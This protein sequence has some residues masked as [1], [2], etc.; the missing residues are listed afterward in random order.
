MLQDK[1]SYAW[2]NTNL[3]RRCDSH[4]FVQGRDRRP[5]CCLEISGLALSPKRKLDTCG[6]AHIQLRVATEMFGMNFMNLCIMLLV[7]LTNVT[8]QNFCEILKEL[9]HSVQDVSKNKT[10]NAVFFFTL[11]LQHPHSLSV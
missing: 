7:S 2:H 11:L 4:Q 5:V 8:V 1:V 3:F 9:Q 6:K 10:R